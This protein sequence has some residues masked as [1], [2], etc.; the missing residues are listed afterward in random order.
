MRRAVT[1]N[2]FLHVA[3]LRGGS[4]GRNP[5]TRTQFPHKNTIAVTLDIGHWMQN[6]V[7]THT[8]AN[9]VTQIFDMNIGSP[10]LVRLIEQEIEDLVS[11]DG[12]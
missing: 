5:G 7:D 8:N 3:G 2:I 12:V 10:E 1:E 6:T 11:T 9:I 4:R